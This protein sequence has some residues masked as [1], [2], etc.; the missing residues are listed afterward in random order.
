M[1]A[2]AAALL[3]AAAAPEHAMNEVVVA[4][5]DRA[6]KGEAQALKGLGIERRVTIAPSWDDRTSVDGAGLVTFRSARSGTDR[7]GAPI[8]VF[9]AALSKEELTA[10]IQAVRNLAAAPPPPM[11][12]EPYET[13]VM[14]E[15]VVDGQVFQFGTKAFPTALA[16][17]QPLLRPLDA[18][19]QK[20][21][22]HPLRSLLLA[23]D[24]PA[25]A[26]RNGPLLLTLR[27]RNGGAEGFWISNPMALPNQ[28]EHER[29]ELVYAPPLVFTPGVQP[30]PEPPMRTP[31][32]PP[33]GARKEEPR[34]LW[35]P[36]KGELAVQLQAHLEAGNA[37]QLAL[38]AELYLDEGE[39]R[40]AGQ[41]RL[42]GSV[43]S[44]DVTVP[45]K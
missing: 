29:A 42:R 25:G 27:L 39:D 4:A 38:R 8:G 32:A 21:Y 7:G 2:L 1:R 40:V 15:A 23:V 3:L 12:V 16:P 22:A 26:P 20:A 34:F 6:L 5:L 36:P 45:V 31:L 13:R 35:M 19:V 17:L 18:A 33:P 37:R 14:V 24:P 30:V 44:A 9:S 28:P 43:F 11:R 10:L 41:P